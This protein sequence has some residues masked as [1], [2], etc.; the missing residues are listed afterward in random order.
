MT[1]PICR[2]ALTSITCR[3][4][5]TRI[6]CRR[7]LTLQVR[8]LIHV[9]PKRGQGHLHSAR[10]Y[11][12][13]LPSGPSA[14]KGTFAGSPTDFFL[15]WCA[16]VNG[17]HN[18]QVRKPIINRLSRNGLRMAV[19]SAKS[20]AGECSERILRQPVKL[21]ILQVPNRAANSAKTKRASRHRC[22]SNSGI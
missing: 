4:A 20:Q 16:A 19:L 1:L 2:R 21:I 17:L 13:P 15:F 14:M 3:R 10:P 18:P 11:A 8:C 9:R 5:L 6:M 12:P 22:G 7:S